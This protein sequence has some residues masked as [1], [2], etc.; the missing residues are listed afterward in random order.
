MQG[1]QQG[2][3]AGGVDA[4]NFNYSPFLPDGTINF[5]AGQILFEV[6]WQRPQDYDLTTGLADP[7]S[8]RTNGSRLPAQSRVYQALKVVSEFN[9]GKFEQTIEGGGENFLF[10]VNHQR[11]NFF[12]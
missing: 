10:A 12:G 8:N 1:L 7:Y 2:N 9:H 6:A 4:A 11:I 5:D 3:F